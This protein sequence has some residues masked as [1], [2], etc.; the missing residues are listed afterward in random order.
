MLLQDNPEGGNR[1]SKEK[2]HN[3]KRCLGLVCTH[4]YLILLHFADAEFYKLKFVATL[5]QASQWYHLPNSVCSA[6][7]CIAFWQFSQYFRL[8]YYYICQGDL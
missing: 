1:Q 4:E 8:H 7:L 3:R 5:G 6:C 2:E